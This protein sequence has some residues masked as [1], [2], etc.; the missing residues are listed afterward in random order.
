MSEIKD[1][2]N[3]KDNTAKILL[4]CAIFIF[5]VSAVFT[6]LNVSY[7]RKCELNYYK[8]TAVITKLTTEHVNT[9]NKKD[10]RYRFTYAYTTED[11][12][13]REVVGK[14]SINKTSL[15][16]YKIYVGEKVEIY[17]DTDTNEAIPVEGAD[18]YSV[19]SVVLFA[20]AEVLY[21]TGSAIYLHEKG[22]KLKHRLLITWLP[23]AV[24]CIVSALLFLIGLPS[25][26]LSELFVRVGGAIGYTVIAALTCICAVVDILISK[27][28]REK[29]ERE[30]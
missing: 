24:I 13:E 20:F 29:V 22:L 8:T 18:I 6:G 15:D 1:N 28:K 4:I 12:A 9:N 3:K 25:G 5:I 23:V 7:M 16:P 17:V 14:R 27:K 2:K 26:G 19:I 30:V 21:V 11:G 10:N